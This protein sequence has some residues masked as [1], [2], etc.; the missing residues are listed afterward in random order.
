VLLL[1]LPLL[2]LALVRPGAALQGAT[3]AQEFDDQQ[4]AMLCMYALAYCH[5][6]GLLRCSKHSNEL[7]PLCAAAA[8]TACLSPLLS[9]LALRHRVPLGIALSSSFFAAAAGAA[10]GPPAAV[11]NIEHSME[12]YNAEV[13]RQRLQQMPDWR[14]PHPWQAVAAAAA[15]TTQRRSNSS[16]SSS[17]KQQHL[18]VNMHAWECCSAGDGDGDDAR[19]VSKVLVRDMAGEPDFVAALVARRWRQQP[20]IDDLQQID[21]EVRRRGKWRHGCSTDCS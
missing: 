9:G 18:E 6:T 13:M 3:G 19:D 16:S 7:T 20:S 15:K 4:T 5:T 21:P 10:T 8:A 17:N 1:L 11:L 2:L 12:G 14:L